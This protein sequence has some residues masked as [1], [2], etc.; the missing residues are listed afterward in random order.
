M[1]CHQRGGDDSADERTHDCTDDDR[2]DGSNGGVNARTRSQFHEGQCVDWCVDTAMLARFS[3]SPSVRSGARVFVAEGDL[4]APLGRCAGV[5][6][7][8]DIFIDTL[9]PSWQVRALR[10]ESRLN[11]TS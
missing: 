5:L 6:S 10:V 2:N 7:E 1:Y 8:I 3:F 4:S 9:W 11:L